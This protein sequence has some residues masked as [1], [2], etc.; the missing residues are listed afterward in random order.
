MTNDETTA[1]DR[2]AASLIAMTKALRAIKKESS[3][4]L[5][6]GDA[7]GAGRRLERIHIAACAALAASNA[8]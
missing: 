8:E 4:I 2:A 1:R 5:D 7:I 6:K 3:R